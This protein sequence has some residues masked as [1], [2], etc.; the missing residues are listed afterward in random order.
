M[1]FQRKITINQVN[2]SLDS[3]IN[4]VPFQS[5]KYQ[6]LSSR[7]QNIQIKTIDNNELIKIKELPWAEGR[8]TFIE[9]TDQLLPKKI[10]NFDFIKI[11]IIKNSSLSGINIKDSEI[12]IGVSLINVPMP[13]NTILNTTK[14]IEFNIQESAPQKI[15]IKPIRKTLKRSVSKEYILQLAQEIVS[16][17]KLQKVKLSFLG[18]YVKVP[19]AEEINYYWK[20]EKLICFLK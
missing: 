8:I 14:M 15:V 10:S 4:S 13:T 16:S 3:R 5:I 17:K 1:F 11:N 9:E 7:T 6:L 18:F 2:L 19:I 20:G 12:K